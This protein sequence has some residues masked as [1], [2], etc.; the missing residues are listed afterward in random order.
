MGPAAPQG[1]WR[2]EAPRRPTWTRK[3][4]RQ[5]AAKWAG[6]PLR[7][8]K[9]RDVDEEAAEAGAVEWEGEP[10]GFEVSMEPMLELLDPKTPDF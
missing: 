6:E 7:S 8:V 3:R 9:A 4:R 1:A 5:G 10:L 2:Q